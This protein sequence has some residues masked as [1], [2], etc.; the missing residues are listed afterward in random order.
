[1]TAVSRPPLTPALVDASALLPTHGLHGAEDVVT[2]WLSVE[3]LLLPGRYC[4]TEPADSLY[5]LAGTRRSNVLVTAPH[6]V[7]HHRPERRKGADVASGGMAL[8]VAALLG[9]RC[10]VAAGE[11][12]HDGNRSPAGT[13]KQA[14]HEA[15]DDGVSVV[16]DIHGMADSFGIDVCLGTGADER[17][18][19][20][21]YE[22]LRLE[23]QAQ[24]RSVSVNDPWGA[25]HPDTVTNTAHA[26]GVAAVQLEVAN[27]WRQPWDHAQRSARFVLG[28][29]AAAEHALPTT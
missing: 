5:A 29:A 1:M 25:S 26:R 28:L 24:G 18:T 3:D 13:F 14:V 7:V 4:G 22:P 20:P 17:G 12:S 10:L 23:L 16:L 27:R 9:A 11:Q 15:I 2:A 8:A 19:R 6:A 21:L